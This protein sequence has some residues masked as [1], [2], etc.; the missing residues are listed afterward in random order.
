MYQPL[1]FCVKLQ[2]HFGGDIHEISVP[3][4]DG[5]EP[6]VNDLMNIIERD[7]RVPRILQNLVFHGQ[8]LHP[9][10]NAPLSCFGIKNLG[11]IRLVGR[12]A[13][14]DKIQQIN[15]Q[16]S[17]HS[18][19]QTSYSPQQQPVVISTAEQYLSYSYPQNR[20]VSTQYDPPKE[21]PPPTPDK[22][23]LPERQATPAE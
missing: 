12:M 6:T 23:K 13:P 20:S 10:I 16:Y 21:Q 9:H 4:Y 19:Q 11:L 14:A 17:P 18:Y 2:L 8:E 22:E 7:F 15:S 5:A 1:V 3:A